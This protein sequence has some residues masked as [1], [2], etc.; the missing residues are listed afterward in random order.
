MTGINAYSAMTA[1]IR[2]MQ[3]RLLSDGDFRELASLSGVPEAVAFLKQFPTYS[4]LFSDLEENRIHRGEI[5]KCLTS[6]IFDDFQK[7]YYFANL[8]QRRMVVLLL[9]RY[10]PTLIKYHL[11]RIQGEDDAHAAS[12][13]T[14]PFLKKNLKLDIDALA[15]CDTMEALIHALK[16]SG[17]DLALKTVFQSPNPSL[18]HYEFALDMYYFSNLWKKKEKYLSGV[19]L[20]VIER[21][22]GSNL[23]LLNIQWIY[24]CKRYFF[25]SP[26]DISA[27]LIPV[28]YKLKKTQLR[29]LIETS[30]PEEF[31]AAIKATYYGRRFERFLPEDFGRGQLEQMHQKILHTVYFS[32]RRNYPYS[33]A[34]INSYIFQKESEISRI[35]TALEGIRYS[36]NTSEIIDYI[37]T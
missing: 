6:A 30:T 21:S 10:V 22:V 17:Y 27:L 1:K 28:H 15:N 2:A 16:G 24:R 18:L 14:H 11:Y 32:D 9:K 31:M 25:L 33:I 4:R 8:E 29:Q 12:F 23:D 7:I 5:E 20:E 36:L 13:Y 19:D 37:T 34:I 3:S 35:V 26:A